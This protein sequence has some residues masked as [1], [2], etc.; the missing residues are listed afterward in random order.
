MFEKVVSTLNSIIWNPA[1]VGLLICAGL[2]FSFRTRFVQIR[3]FSMMLKSLFTKMSVDG[4]GISSFQ[5]FCLALSGRVGTGNIVGVATAIAF[6]GPGAVFW[7][8]VVAFLGAS[9]A[10]VESTLAQIYR[11]PH[12]SGFRGGPFS[13]IDYGLG[14]RWLGVIVA[15][16]TVIS[17]GV[18]LTTVQTNGAASAALN[19]FSVSPWISG[20]VLAVLLALVVI[21]GV[22]RIARVAAWITP[23][24]ALGYILMAIV[25]IIAHHESIPAVFASIFTNAF[26]IHPV[27]GGIIGSTIAMGVKRGIFSNE[28]GQG[29]GAIVSAAA[30]VPHPAQQGL[31]ISFSVYVDTLLVCTATALMILSSGTYNILDSKTGE[32]LYSGAPELANN[33]VNYTQSAVDTVFAGFGS[34][35]VSVA[36]IF[37]VFSTL[38]AYY[39]YAESGILYLFRGR[40]HRYEQIAVRILQGIMLAAAVFGAINEADLIWQLGDIG[41]GLMAWLTVISILILCPKAVSALKEY[42]ALHKR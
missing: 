14:L 23:F 29:T 9:T 34:Q 16:I 38:I 35:F 15:F 37:F 8:W 4:N 11:F 41:V 20:V 12:K 31:S 28:A 1:L 21:G 30:D 19:A 24:M 5:A 26:G 7:M 2:Y 40:D 13:I 6:G 33:Y 18:F 42:E 39:F 36:M 25:V 10:F 22:K 32:I 27:C 3:R 17:C